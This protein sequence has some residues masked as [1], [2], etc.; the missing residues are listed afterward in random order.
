MKIKQPLLIP[1]ISLLFLSL[2]SINCN[3]QT[4]QEKNLAVVKAELPKNLDE[5]D[6]DNF[7]EEEWENFNNAVND[8]KIQ[9]PKAG[10]RKI[11]DAELDSKFSVGLSDIYDALDDYT[12]EFSNLD[13]R[14][15][16]KPE[17][18]QTSAE[19]VKFKTAKYIDGHTIWCFKGETHNGKPHGFGV[20]NL[21]ENC[22]NSF[23][24]IAEFKHGK[25]NSDVAVFGFGNLLGEGHI[26]NGQK[27]GVWTD[28]AMN[29][30]ITLSANYKNGKLIAGPV[31]I[32]NQRYPVLRGLGTGIADQYVG[33]LDAKGEL[34]GATVPVSFTAID[35]NGSEYSFNG[36]ELK[37]HKPGA[38][39]ANY[40]MVSES[41]TGPFV[42]NGPCSISFATG[43]TT[44]GACSELAEGSY[45]TRYISGY[46][47]Y[48]YANGFF[49][50]STCDK[51]GLV[52]GSLSY[53]TGPGIDNQWVDIDSSRSFNYK[54]PGKWRTFRDKVGGVLKDGLKLYHDPETWFNPKIW[55]DT[56]QRG[57]KEF[58]RVMEKNPKIA[59][60][61]EAACGPNTGGCNY[62]SPIGNVNDS[63]YYEAETSVNG[64]IQTVSVKPQ[65]YRSFAST[66]KID[67]GDKLDALK[68]YWGVFQLAAY[69]RSLNEAR[70]KLSK[71]LGPGES[72]NIECVSQ[73][74][75]VLE[76]H[77]YDGNESF[78]DPA[79]IYTRGTVYGKTSIWDIIPESAL[80]KSQR[81]NELL[82]TLPEWIQQEEFLY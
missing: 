14:T 10:T 28:Y 67:N 23:L 49:L 15:P 55:E 2:L 52:P 71:T 20:L 42:A 39:T 79:K 82:K 46:C 75:R 31:I 56:A 77:P 22:K 12:I 27:E 34:T 21:A 13:T 72:L 74:A 18:E 58:N 6:T 32:G 48:N 26:F 11:E 3:A 60:A 38:Y 51:S 78:K 64:K 17:S 69:D 70:L 63:F 35:T 66:Y 4:K 36:S 40:T 16:L 1:L 76:C 50:T 62:T 59:K 61:L 33:Y 9:L 24:M 37:L 80:Q 65:G 5:V 47:E 81:E 44:R 54:V 41:D 7:T 45:I 8:I 25:I 43:T 57:L 19:F 73:Y 68:F 29:K 53:L 30:I